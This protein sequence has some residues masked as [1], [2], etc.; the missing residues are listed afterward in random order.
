MLTKLSKKCVKTVPG[1][2]KV[3]QKWPPGS[4][5]GPKMDPEIDENLMKIQ[6]GVGLGQSS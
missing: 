5:K 4:P 2:A 1:V 3:A 6:S